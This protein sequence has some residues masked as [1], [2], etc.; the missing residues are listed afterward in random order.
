MADSV[1]ISS[2][3]NS[4]VF[5]ASVSKLNGLKISVK[6]RSFMISTKEIQKAII[7]A[8]IQRAK[9]LL[10]YLKGFNLNSPVSSNLV[11]IFKTRRN[12]RNCCSH[13]PYK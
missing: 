11:D 6:G 8:F 5:V 9:I 12:W 1:I 10:K 4:Y 13:V 2:T 7:M 3:A